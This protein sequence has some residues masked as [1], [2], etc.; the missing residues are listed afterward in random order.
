ME[1][2]RTDG[3]RGIMPKPMLAASLSVVNLTDGTGSGYWGERRIT[4][5]DVGPKETSEWRPRCKDSGSGYWR[6]VMRPTTFVE[7][8]VS[9]VIDLRN[10][11]KSCAVRLRGWLPSFYLFW[12]DQG[13]ASDVEKPAKYSM[14]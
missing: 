1:V 14:A 3:T 10:I 7:R 11:L 5:G 9:N 8:R 12:T 2:S 4:G 13:Q 6:V